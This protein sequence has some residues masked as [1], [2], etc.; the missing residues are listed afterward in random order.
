MWTKDN[1]VNDLR[2]MGL[3]SDD[4]VMLHTSLKSI[5]EIEGGAD[6]LIDAL[7]EV[8]SDG[9]FVIPAHTW[10]NVPRLEPVFDVRTSEPCTGMI[11]V[12]ACKRKDGIRSLNATH[13][14]VAFGKDAAEFVR[15]EE[16]TTSPCDPTGICGK[17]LVRHAKILLIGVNHD[18]NTII[19]GIEEI[20]DIPNRISE[21]ARAIPVIDYEGREIITHIKYHC[22]YPLSKY[23]V[24]FEPAFIKYGAQKE[25]PLGN[26][27]VKVCDSHE[28]FRVLQNIYRKT[29][30]EL[31]EDLE[32]LPENLY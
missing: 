2:A 3:R 10:K 20:L 22:R 6:T 27:T 19:H 21:E 32:P 28:L 5:G 17:L 16:K 25:Y 29:D 7:K 1:L 12:V 24:K 23:Y 11:S 18:R 8:L 15:G 13:S 4:T 9:L 31:C 26:A 30:A 14:V